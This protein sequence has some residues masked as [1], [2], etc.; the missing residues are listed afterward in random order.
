MMICKSPI[1]LPQSRSPIT[2]A[3]LHQLPEGDDV[4]LAHY[5]VTGEVQGLDLERFDAT[6]ESSSVRST[7][8]LSLVDSDASSLHQRLLLGPTGD[9][10]C[11]FK[12]IRL[13]RKLALRSMPRRTKAR[14]NWVIFLLK[15]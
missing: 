12:L 9:S 2:S 1:S 14:R 8:H 3:S 13:V 15:P 10:C 6:G 7:H 11:T 5:E 4:W